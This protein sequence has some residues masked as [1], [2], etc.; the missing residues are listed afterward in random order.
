MRFPTQSD[1]DILVLLLS[2]LRFERFG[3]ILALAPL[4]L[5]AC[6]SGGKSDSGQTCPRSCPVATATATI[7]VTTMPAQVVNGVEAVLAGPVNGT[8]VCQPHPPV[9]WVLCEWPSG[10]AVVA[11]TYSVQVSAPG[12]EATTVQLEVNTPPPDPC[13]C[14]FDSVEPSIVSISAADGGVD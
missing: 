9:S 2:T 3:S 14:A 4:T 11:G 13:G 8:M 5:A 6:G 12:Y 7:A 10:V 1:C